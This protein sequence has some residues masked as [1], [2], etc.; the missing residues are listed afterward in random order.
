MLDDQFTRSSLQLV[1][2][3]GLQ[4]REALVVE[5]HLSQHGGGQVAR[6]LETLRLLEQVDAVDLQLG[7]AVSGGVVDL[8]GQVDE[9]TVRPELLLEGA[10]VLVEHRCQCASAGD[11]IT[12]ELGVR[13][14]RALADGHRQLDVVA[15]EDR[16]PFRGDVDG[17]HALR[18]PEGCI[19]R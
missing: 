13:P 4:A 1:L 2:V 11:G 6:R 16:A 18:L 10:L 17:A 12:H 9:P 19:A 7:H 5:T 15:V 8:A 3:L 14:H